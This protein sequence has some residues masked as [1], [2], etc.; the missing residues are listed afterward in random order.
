MTPH[1]AP[2]RE[3]GGS[4]STGRIVVVDDHED[5]VELLRVRLE[6]WGYQVETARDGSEALQR[7]EESPPD[8]ILLD[9]MMPEVDGNEVARRIKHNPALPFIPIIMQTALDSTESKVEGLEAGADDYITKPIEFAELKARLR[10]ML[11]IKRQ[12]GR[13]SCR[14]R[15]LL[16]R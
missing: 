3:A 2:G 8:L 16:S 1:E 11:R 5:N 10:S 14:G 12:I 15:V 13:A 9:V 7:V 6:A 4:E